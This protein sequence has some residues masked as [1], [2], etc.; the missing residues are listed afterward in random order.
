MRTLSVV[1]ASLALPG[2]S[3]L[4]FGPAGGPMMP[5]DWLVGFVFLVFI[6]YC[7]LIKKE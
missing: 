5:W 4:F 2:C 1:V 3:R 7:I 6:G